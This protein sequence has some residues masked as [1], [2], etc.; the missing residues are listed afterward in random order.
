MQILSYQLRKVFDM[1]CNQLATHPWREQDGVVYF[2]VTSRGT[3][4]KQ[5]IDYFK[6]KGYCT[7]D[8]AKSIL[9]DPEFGTTT[10]VTT[11]IAVFKGVLLKDDERT[12]KKISAKALSFNWFKPRAEV[13]CLIRETFSDNEIEAMGLNLITVMHEPF[14]WPYCGSAV[15]LSIGSKECGP[16]LYPCYNRPYN[17]LILNHGF[18]FS[19][20]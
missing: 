4:G 17:G 7:Y 2:T 5:W 10:G 12:P 9:N 18:A 3:T 15:R 13:A 11:E 1:K 20:P 8:H 14:E 6:K 16:G 19:R